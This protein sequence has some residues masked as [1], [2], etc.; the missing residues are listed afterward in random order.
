[1]A[2]LGLQGKLL[3]FMAIRTEALT[4][5]KLMQHSLPQTLK[6]LAN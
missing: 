1:L 5:T 4:G 2:S 6:T 3:E